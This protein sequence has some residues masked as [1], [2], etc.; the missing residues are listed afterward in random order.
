MCTELIWSS[1]KQNTDMKTV[2][3]V[4]KG[5]ARR[6][7]FL[8]L[9]LGLLGMWGAST[10]YGQQRGSRIVD[11]SA[12]VTQW[13][14]R[15][16]SIV[17]PIQANNVKVLCY[18]KNGS[19]PSS[20]DFNKVPTKSYQYTPDAQHER[21][22]IKKTYDNKSIAA[23]KEYIV[24]VKCVNG[25][26]LSVKLGAD[27]KRTD[28]NKDLYDILHW[29]TSK[30]VGMYDAFRGCSNL[31]VITADDAPS[32]TTWSGGTV[33]DNNGFFADCTALTKIN[34]LSN[35]ATK[36]SNVTTA[37][38]MFSGCKAFKGE[39]LQTWQLSSVTLSLIHI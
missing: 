30:F 5:G 20:S 22:E 35:W 6:L 2:E 1:N 25:D 3:S 36:V 31:T 28:A 26:N 29:G 37:A 21:N 10:A 17:F 27:K 4:W 23:N 13:K 14:P 15:S 32:F 16:N 18:E 8:S 9:L 33:V 24:E 34:S 38:Y 19:T 7:A 11:Q 12:F 39:G